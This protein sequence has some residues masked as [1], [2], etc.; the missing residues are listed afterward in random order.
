MFKNSQRHPNPCLGIGCFIFALGCFSG[1]SSMPTADLPVN[2]S[3]QEQAFQMDQAVSNGEANHFNLLDQDDFNAC[4]AHLKIAEEKLGAHESDDQVLNELKISLGYYQEA[5]KT[6]NERKSQ[7]E[8]ILYARS[9]SV[10]AGALQFQK[11]K[12]DLDKVDQDFR[13]LADSDEVPKTAE[14]SNFQRRYGQVELEA[15]EA[16]QLG[17]AK[18]K[19]DQALT[20]GADT[21]AP[22][23]LRRAQ[24][25]Y[26]RA[27]DAISMDRSHPDSYSEQVKDANLDADRLA[28]VMDLQRADPSHF[29]EEQALRSVDGVGNQQMQRTQLR[30]TQ[31]VK[32]KS[33]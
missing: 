23:A 29:N 22:E 3:P 12:N 13:K 7:L 25:D 4:K 10:W 1:C 9:D 24:E 33:D 31:K 21:K 17:S 16:G 18:A 2:I 26:Q 27:K 15:L 28:Q 6:S 11:S 8:T 14:L 32:T 19:I 5:E 20:Q 30:P